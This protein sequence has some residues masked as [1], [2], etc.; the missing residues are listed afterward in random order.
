M[1]LAYCDAC[2]FR[3]PEGDLSSGAATEPDENHF[4]CAKC[5]AVSDVVSAGFN[6]TVFPQANAGA[7]FHAAM[8]SGKFHGIIWPATPTGRGVR[9]GKAY[10]NLSAQPA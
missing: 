8:S 4:L 6:T 3:I 10:A 9:P 5:N 7:V 2:G 1:R